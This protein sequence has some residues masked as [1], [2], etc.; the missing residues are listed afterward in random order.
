MNTTATFQPVRD[1]NGNITGITAASGDY[2]ADGVNNDYPNVG[3]YTMATGRQAYLTGV[4][5]RSNFTVPTL[6]TEGNEKW[7]Q[8]RN[9]G[10]AET[11]ASLSKDTNITET[12]APGDSVR[13][14][15]YLQPRE[16]GRDLVELV[17]FDVRPLDLA[18]ES[19][20]DSDRR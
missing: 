6:G 17:E 1:S 20:M 14:L 3:S 9:P 16:S 11:D 10:F 15:Q 2:N 5:P 7:G 18:T 8:F 19:A 12:I 4:F 13:V